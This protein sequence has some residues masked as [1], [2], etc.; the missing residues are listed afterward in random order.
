VAIS[1]KGD[2]FATTDAI[3]I[4]ANTHIGK[5]QF[6]QQSRPRLKENFTGNTWKSES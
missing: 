3:K 2:L 4:R 6:E 5:T 1:K